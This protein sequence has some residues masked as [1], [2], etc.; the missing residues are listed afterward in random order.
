MTFPLY[1]S[2]VR[3]DNAVPERILTTLLDLLLCSLLLC[4]VVEAA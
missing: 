1:K 3:F 2:V 4:T